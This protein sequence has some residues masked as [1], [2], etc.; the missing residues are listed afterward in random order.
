MKA[1]LLT[2]GSRGDVQPFA[3]LAAALTDAGHE[4]VVAGPA[5]SVAMAD[6]FCARVIPLDDGTNKLVDDRAAW[7]AVERNF[8][9]LRGKRL[10]LGLLRRNRVAMRR[11]FGAD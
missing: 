7:E 5:S 8:R 10:G 1:L 11:V 4:V 9:G 6:P 3:A 2:H